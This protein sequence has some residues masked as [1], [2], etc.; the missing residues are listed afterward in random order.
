VARRCV[1]AW[2]PLA[3]LVHQ[4]QGVLG[5][6]MGQ[7]QINHGGSDLLVTEELLDGVQVRAGFKKVGGG[8]SQ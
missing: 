8:S 7:V 2:Q 1:L 4:A 5:A 3:E 6:L